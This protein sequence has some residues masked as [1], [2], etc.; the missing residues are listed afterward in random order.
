MNSRQ[1][2]SSLL[3]VVV[4]GSVGVFAWQRS[5]RPSGNPPSDVQAPVAPAPA[6]PSI[7]ADKAPTPVADAAAEKPAVPSVP[8]TDAAA[9]A[10]VVV[11]YFTT[12][13]RCDSCRKIEALSRRAVLEGF[14]EQVAAGRVAFRI[15]NTDEPEHAHYV[16]HYSITNKIV[17]V[18]HQRDGKEIEWTPRQDVWLHFEEPPE[19]FAYVRE[20]IQ[21][22]LAAK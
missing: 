18:S 8:V 19:F 14:P 5:Q 6:N 22:Y 3:L 7:P 4:F 9:K 12:N 20:P 11:T 16:D 15:V 1:L 21:A 2:V 10:D 17:I 13:V